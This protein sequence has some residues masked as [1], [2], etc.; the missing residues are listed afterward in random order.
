MDELGCAHFLCN[1]RNGPATFDF[2]TVYGN[3]SLLGDYLG[4]FVPHTNHEQDVVSHFP[5]LVQGCGSPGYTLA[6]YDS[7]DIR[8]SGQFGN[9]SNECFLLLHKIVWVSNVNHAVPVALYHYFCCPVLIF[10]LRYSTSDNTYLEAGLTTGLL[11]VSTAAYHGDCEY[12]QQQQY[13]SI[14]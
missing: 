3:V 6:D 13:D 9:T 11:A 5:D 8:V 1:L 2:V 10:S 14:S 4:V 7:F 12:C